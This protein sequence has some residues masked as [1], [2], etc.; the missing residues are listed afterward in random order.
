MWGR[1]HCEKRGNSLSLVISPVLT[2]F[3]TAISFVRQNAALR[4]NGLK[5]IECIC[6]KFRFMSACADSAG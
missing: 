3:S 4:G 6:E 2:M 5:G 1:K